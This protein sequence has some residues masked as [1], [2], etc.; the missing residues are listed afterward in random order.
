M[1]QVHNKL[2]GQALLDYVHA[3]TDSMNRVELCRGAG[4]LK[5]TVEGKGCDFISFYE[6]ILDARKANGEYKVVTNGEYYEMNGGDGYED[7]LDN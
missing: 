5:D 2:T 1:S 6:S 7:V 4:H 3:N